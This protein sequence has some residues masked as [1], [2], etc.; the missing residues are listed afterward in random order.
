MVFRSYVCTSLQLAVENKHIVKTYD[1]II[2]PAPVDDRT[3]EEIAADFIARHGLKTE[4]A[5]EHI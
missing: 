2:H 5:N 1:E 3:G 4:E